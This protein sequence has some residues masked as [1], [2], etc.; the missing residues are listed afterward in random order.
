MYLW[1]ACKKTKIENYSSPDVSNL[2]WNSQWKVSPTSGQP[3]EPLGS[4]RLL[5]LSRVRLQRRLHSC[6][7]SASSRSA[8]R[9]EV[10]AVARADSTPSWARG[11][12]S[13][14]PVR[15][16]ASTCVCA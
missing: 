7:V 11:N 8:D 4:G 15:F 6:R 9:T 10:S 3:M 12:I 5:S 16:P 2:T 1:N 13:S 14:E